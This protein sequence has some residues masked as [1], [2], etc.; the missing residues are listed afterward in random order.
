MK[1]KIYIAGIQL[2]MYKEREFPLWLSDIE[3]D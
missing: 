3:P 2:E 1:S